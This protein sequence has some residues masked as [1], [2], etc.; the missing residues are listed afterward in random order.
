MTNFV[1]MDFNPWFS[2]LH[3][4]QN[5]VGMTYMFQAKSFFLFTI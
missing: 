5:A 3:I 2:K 4:L 1:I